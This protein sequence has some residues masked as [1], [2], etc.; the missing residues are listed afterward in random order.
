[1]TTQQFRLHDIEWDAVR[2]AD[3]PYFLSNPHMYMV[4][5]LGG[6]LTAYGDEQSH[7]RPCWWRRCTCTIRQQLRGMVK[8][9][10][11]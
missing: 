9:H 7:S 11:S 4:A 6:D 3:T 2:P 5:S 1:M 8:L 10:L